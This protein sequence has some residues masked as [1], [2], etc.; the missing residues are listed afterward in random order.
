MPRY[1]IWQSFCIRSEQKTWK[2]LFLSYQ[3]TATWVCIHISH[4]IVLGSVP[5]SHYS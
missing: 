4:K 2:R 3:F 1:W 5:F